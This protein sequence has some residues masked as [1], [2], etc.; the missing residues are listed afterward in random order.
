MA[1]LLEVAFLKLV[2]QVCV[3]QVPPFGI[4]LSCCT[5]D[6][7]QNAEY[8]LTVFTIDISASQTPRFSV[9]YD[10]GH[11]CADSV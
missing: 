6:L 10:N 2:Y 4:P 8:L 1:T 3:E 9:P 11:Q 7:S 5:M